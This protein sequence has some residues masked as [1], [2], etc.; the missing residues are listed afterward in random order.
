MSNTAHV[1]LKS[2]LAECRFEWLDYDGDDC[3]RN[4][5]IDVRVENRCQRFR[6]GPC[7]INGL[8]QLSRLVRNGIQNTFSF[9]SCHPNIRDVDLYREKDGY[10]LVVRSETAV[11]REEV[12]IRNPRIEVED[13][14]LERFIRGR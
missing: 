8:R 12:Y 14:I 3:F 2:D 9:V 11:L 13:E 5:Y 6:L 7:V 10:R 4:F 1:Y